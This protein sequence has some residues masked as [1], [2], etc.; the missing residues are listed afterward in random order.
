MVMQRLFI[1]LTVCLVL[2]LPDAHAQDKALKTDPAGLDSETGNGSAPIELEPITYTEGGESAARAKDP[3]EGYPETIVHE[4][5]AVPSISTET[6]PG[7][8]KKISVDLRGMSVADV[9]K[10]IAVE[11]DLN[12]AIAPDVSGVVNLLINDV[13]IKDIFEIILATNRLAYRVQGN[14]ITVISNNEY[15][16]LEGVDFFDNRRTVVY[17]LKYASAQALGTFLGNIKSDIGKIIF[18]DST[19]ML[20][21]IDTPPKIE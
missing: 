2:A 11:G 12:I 9:L 14:I 10:F 8:E 4:G 17:Q 1:I 21:L 20:V 18:D 6:F 16:I 13:S 19:G 7:F 3:A 15:R 5:G